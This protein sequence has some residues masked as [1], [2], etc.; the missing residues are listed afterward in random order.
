MTGRDLVSAS[1]R[2]IGALAP[3]ESLA[4]SE[5]TDGLS[6]LNRMLSSWST[7]ELLIYARVREEFTLTP[8]TASYTLG[9]GGDFSTTRPLRIDEAL[10]RDET[11]TPAVEYPVRILSLAEWASIRLKGVSYDR[12]TALYAEGT[13]PLETL[14]LYPMPSAAHKL[15]L[16]SWKPLTEV[17]TLDTAVAFPPGYEEALVYGLALRLTPEYGKAVPDAVAIV[18]VEAKANIKRMNHRPQYLR[19]DEALISEGGFNIL[20][21]DPT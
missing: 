15:V 19:V 12:V 6:A 5:A 17:S 8:S 1:L 13:Y 9:T 18:A 7:E 2:L 20:T 10:L 4:S 14:N 3:G 16:W 11:Q 21:G